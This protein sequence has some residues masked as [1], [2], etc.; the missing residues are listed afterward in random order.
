MSVT[1]IEKKFKPLLIKIRIDEKII[2]EP[3]LF[4]WEDTLSKNIKHIDKVSLNQNIEYYSSINKDVS[5]FENGITFKVVYLKDHKCIFSYEFKNLSFITG[6]N[7]LYIS[8]N[9]YSGYSYA[10]RNYIYQLLQSGYNVQWTDTFTSSNTYKPINYQEQLVFDCL[11]NKIDY[12]SIII[13]HTPE[14][15]NFICDKIP[16]NKKIY[17]LTTWETTR[18]HPEWINFIN[19]SVDEVIV[20]SK[21]NI[22]TFKLSGVNKPLNLWTH[23]IFPINK[24]NINPENICNKI[25]I[26]NNFEFKE[27]PLLVKNILENNTVYYNISQYTN[28]KNLRQII[29]SFCQRFTINDNVCLLIK[30]YIQ[31]FTEK[32]ID[33][34]KYKIVE[35][36]RQFKNLPKILFCFENL[37]T[38]EINTIH[39]IGDVY[40]TLNRGEGFGLCTY[41][42]KKIGNKI[43]C[44]KFGAEKEFLDEDDILLDYTLA[45]SDY[46]DDFNKYYI[47]NDQMCAFY[48]TD[49]VISKLKYFPKITEKIYILS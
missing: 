16:R 41:T 37:N 43:I 18:L 30:T 32:E 46:L 39:V 24:S 44:G 10:A 49:Y 11:N 42:A 26:F 9:S 40:F 29:S 27:N 15:W 13:H 36:T 2:N 8:Q 1:L 35:L 25:T 5:F 3:C 38:D 23:D 47:G 7:I 14:S 20:P 45:S 6:K 12:D 28:R 19:N 4:I 21:F 48:D 22:E 33:A 17:G 31:S 34:L